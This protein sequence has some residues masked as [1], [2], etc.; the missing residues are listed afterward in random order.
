MML[1]SLA[2]RGLR[3]PLMALALAA[4]PGAP[5]QAADGRGTLRRLAVLLQAAPG[6]GV[7]REI[8]AEIHATALADL[9]ASGAFRQVE[10]AGADHR[11]P[12]GGLLLKVAPRA[13]AAGTLLLEALCLEPA[14]H[15]I[16]WKRAFQGPVGAARRMAHRVADDLVGLVTGVP[17]AADSAFVF[18][19]DLPRGIREIHAV[20]RD[21]SG[22]RPLTAFQSLTDY[23]ALS[24][25]GRLAVVSYKAGPPQIWAQRTPQAPLVPLSSHTPTRGMGIRDLA[26]SPDGRLIAFVQDTPR[27]LSGIQTLDPATT[28]RTALTPGDHLDTCPTWSP[29]SQRLAFVSDRAGVAQVFVQDL[30]GGQPRQLTRDG[31]P[32]VAAAWSP[33]GDRIA[34]AARQDGATRLLLLAPDGTGVTEVARWSQTVRGLRWSPDG[35]SLLVEIQDGGRSRFL[36][37][38]PGGKVQPADGLPTGARGP[39][40]V[41]L[42]TAG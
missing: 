36:I 31:A 22:E 21:G 26:W 12:G 33:L 17:G 32:K 8:A 25:D 7:G 34:V 30:H 3:L 38:E 42:A 35:R 13:G 37:A 5:A 20:A 6:A 14:T 9:Q 24:A 40:W 23:P 19:K 16:L 2:N 39:L 4:L 41:K 29:D 18:A 27:G 15:R 10:A 11:E 1:R 28:A